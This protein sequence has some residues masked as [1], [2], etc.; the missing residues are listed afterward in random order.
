[1]LS[2]APPV[3]LKIIYCSVKL[4][5]K[6]KIPQRTRYFFSSCCGAQSLQ[7]SYGAAA[8]IVTGIKQ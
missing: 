6:T 8:H 2:L 5:A 4:Q 1:M 3:E 7:K